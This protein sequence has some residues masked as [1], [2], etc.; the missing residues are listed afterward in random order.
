MSESSTPVQS[1]KALLEINNVPNRNRETFELHLM[2]A[3]TNNF[4]ITAPSFWMRPEV[5]ETIEEIDNN[6]SIFYWR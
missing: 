6:G 2:S 1:F 4:F 5:K 3:Y